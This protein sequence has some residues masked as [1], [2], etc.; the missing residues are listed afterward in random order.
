MKIKLSL[1]IPLGLGLAV[2]ATQGH[3]ADLPQAYQSPR[4]ITSEP[5]VDY[6]WNGFYVGA[7]LGL[8]WE[9]GNTHATA[10][11][12]KG[13]P[14]SISSPSVNAPAKGALGG[15]Q[16]GYNYRIGNMFVLGTEA[17]F[18]WSGMSSKWSD[19][20]AAA[21]PGFPG[22]SLS[23]QNSGET[24]MNW[25]STVRG[26]VGVLASPIF[27]LYGTGGLA[28][29]DVS[30]SYGTGVFLGSTCLVDCGGSTVSGVRYGWTAGVGMEYAINNHWSVKGEWLHYDLGKV[31]G[32]YHTSGIPF[33]PVY[34]VNW[35]TK[36]DGE[37]ARFGF[38]YKLP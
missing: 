15:A 17:D 10:V 35:S 38:N 2:T 32:S 20:W 3:A 30:S 9:N 22:A 27:M 14:L 16:I 29:A 5:P 33:A 18:D 7:N 13:F 28:I 8:G 24:K 6:L 26:R 34:N 25:F 19:V 23:L 4:I 31:S 36:V 21:I 12:T 1:L 37:I 11:E